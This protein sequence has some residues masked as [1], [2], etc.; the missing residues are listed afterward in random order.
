MA[1]R[2]PMKWRLSVVAAACCASACAAQTSQPADAG[3]PMM[4]QTE[5]QYP[6]GGFL[7][8][9]RADALEKLRHYGEGVG[10]RLEPYP[11]SPTQPAL[12]LSGAE[13][14][15]KMEATRDLVNK[16]QAGR[17]GDVRLGLISEQPPR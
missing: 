3:L 14:F 8:T 1:L 17:F 7:F 10:L 4:E 5:P 2:E 13:A 15:G 9:G 16:S 11:Q 6:F 12:L